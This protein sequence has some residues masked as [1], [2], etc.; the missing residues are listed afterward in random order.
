MIIKINNIPRF[1]QAEI[2]KLQSKL[3]PL[4]KKNMKYGFF[5]P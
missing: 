3:S 5:Q 2:E 4:L 1:M